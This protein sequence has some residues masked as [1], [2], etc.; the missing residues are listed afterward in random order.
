MW[1]DTLG[2]VSPMNGIARGLSPVELA[3]CVGAADQAQG[4]RELD[5]KLQPVEDAA[6]WEEA[7]LNGVE[8]VVAHSLMRNQ[9]KDDTAE[10]WRNAH[11]DTYK[12]ISAYVAEL[13]RIALLLNSGGIRLVA[14]KNAG[15]ARGLGVCLGCCPMGDLDVLVDQA[16]FLAA[17]R[18]LEQ[19][20]YQF[21]FRS[22]LEVADLQSAEAS[23][24]AEYWRPLAEGERLWLELQWRPISG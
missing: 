19:D 23:G 18:L 21:E 17:H 20:G 12:R 13:N 9:G 24:G 15:I 4:V 1:G 8:S 7:R 2:Y 14:L 11:D 6:L 5:A 10:P 3:I 22:P 16:G